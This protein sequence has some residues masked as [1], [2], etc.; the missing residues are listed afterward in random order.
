MGLLLLA[1]MADATIASGSINQLA[2]NTN[3]N[4]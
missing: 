4:T 3:L 1:K 2:Y